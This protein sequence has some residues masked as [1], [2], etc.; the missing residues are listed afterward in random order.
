MTIYVDADACPVKDEIIRV[1]E[2]HQVEMLFVCD[3][4]LR[5][6]N[7][8]W[9][10]LVIVEGKLDA[11]D[12]WIAEH[13]GPGDVFVTAD[14]P[15]A[16]RCIKAGGIG[17]DPRGKLWTVDNIGAALAT[18]NLMTDLREAGAVTSGAK[19]FG[20]KDRSA[21]LD[22]MERVMRAAAAK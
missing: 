10:R 4:G 19:P 9:A 20:P 2:R 11:A 3:G 18:R 22:G 8:Q 1:G 12:D 16:D 7:S 15:L 14:I 6:P 5:R 17:I 13:I 21:F